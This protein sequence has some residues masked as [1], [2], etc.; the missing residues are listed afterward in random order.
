MVLRSHIHRE[1]TQGV[2]GAGALTTVKRVPKLGEGVNREAVMWL[3]NERH[4]IAHPL[5]T[6][7]TVERVPKLREGVNREAVIRLAKDRHSTAQLR[8]RVTSLTS[9]EIA[10]TS[11]REGA[12]APAPRVP[13]AP[14]GR[15][16]HD[17]GS[18]TSHC[19]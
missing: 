15:D 13:L 4:S 10:Q 19:V 17:T 8:G 14:Q 6:L 1:T 9:H 18:R 16:C 3:A 5:A 11:R 7:A 2:H 12:C